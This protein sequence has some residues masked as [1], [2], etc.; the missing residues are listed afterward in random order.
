MTCREFADFIGDYLSG[1]LVAEQRTSF[2]H[3][4]VIC[5]NCRTYLTQY[6]Q[7]IELGRRAFQDPDAAVPGEIPEDLVRAILSARQSK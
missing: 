3:H 5:D 4:L 7:A 1:E 2:E 6:Q